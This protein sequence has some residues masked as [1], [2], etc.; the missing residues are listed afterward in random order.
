[1]RT[2][3]RTTAII[4]AIAI[5]GTVGIG[6]V[7]GLP[8][9]ASVRATP[10]GTVILHFYERTESHTGYTAAGTPSTSEPMA[11]D[12]FDSTNLDYVGNHSHHAKR[13]TASDHVYCSLISDTIAQCSG[14]FAIGGS[15]I[16]TDVF[17]LQLGPTPVVAPIAGG[18]GAYA[19]MT[20]T[21]KSVD[22]GDTG[23]G[24]VTL[25]LHKK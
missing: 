21:L 16:Y 3:S 12:R 2:T 1:M 4:A 15:M 20:G 10:P 19:G 13:W 23:N 17:T 24:D 25:T 7:A 22:V 5:V 9:V 18:S 14:Q 8:A 11:G 6:L